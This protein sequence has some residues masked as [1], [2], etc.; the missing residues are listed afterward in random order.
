[1]KQLI[2]LSDKAAQRI[3]EILSNDTTSLGVRIGVKAED[4]L[5]CLMLWN[6]P[7]NQNLM[8]NS[9]RKKG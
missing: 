9:L 7:K 1:M 5:A 6:M 2:K 8:M 4:V 3:K